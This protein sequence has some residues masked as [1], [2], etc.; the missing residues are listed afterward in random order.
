VKQSLGK[1][2]V[3][4]SIEQGIALSY[5]DK[6]PNVKLKKVEAFLKMR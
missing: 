2:E 6:N 1:S 5:R 4:V 3:K